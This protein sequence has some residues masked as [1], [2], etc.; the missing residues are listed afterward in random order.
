MEWA[1]AGP[2]TLQQRL[3]HLDAKKI[4]AMDVEDFVAVC[5]EKPAIHRFP[6]SMGRRIHDLCVLLAD[7]Y[8]GKGANVWKGVESGDEL[9]RRLREL[10]GY[11]EE[12]SKIFVAILGKRMSV[13]PTDWRV[14]AGVFG[15]DV[16][17]SVADI[18]GPESL[19][20]V[21]EW[22][23]A[24]KAAKK[25]KQDEPRPPERRHTVHPRHRRRPVADTIVL[26]PGPLRR[27]VRHLRLLRTQPG[28]HRTGAAQLAPADPQRPD[29]R[30]RAPSRQP[31]GDGAL[32]AP[33]PDL[34]VRDQ[35]C[36]GAPRRRSR[37]VA[38][39][40]HGAARSTA[41]DEPDRRDGRGAHRHRRRLDAHQVGPVRTDP[42]DRLD[43]DAA[44][45]APCSPELVASMAGGC[46]SL[47]DHRSDPAGRSPPARVPD[48][49][50][51][52]RGHRRVRLRRPAL[53]PA[54]SRRR[55]RC[56]RRLY[57]PAAARCGVVR[58]CGQR[59]QGRPGPRP[60]PAAGAVAHTRGLL[61]G[62]FSARCRIAI[63]RSSPAG[64]RASRS[65]ASSLRSWS[66][67]ASS[68]QS[69]SGDHARGPLHWPRPPCCRSPGRSVL[70]RS[71]YRLAYEIVPGFDLARGAA[72]WVVIVVLV[73]ALF[74]GVGVDVIRR[75]AQ[76]R[77]VAAAMIAIAGVVGLVALDVVD[78]FD[79]RSGSHLGR[80]PRPWRWR[81]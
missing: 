30:W 24:Q 72:R 35:P 79:R 13:E 7:R 29:L 52:D 56:A 45:G 28:G 38:R 57:R 75:R 48:G 31:V 53:A 43:S 33:A 51:G 73:A 2:A 16:P 59:D 41:R 62:H 54:R 50:V 65:S 3:G 81:C 46:C 23:K 27:R 17:R 37:R 80:S 1:F 36:D 47:G 49:R 44:R 21:R 19:G 60:A 40:R 6:A 58:H 10:P 11:G 77:H 69:S 67:S 9:Y 32:P 74:A 22:K 64:S 34:A 63:R 42:G 39:C 26:V 70:E 66:P 25:D 71:I 5:C 15:D 61:F 14:A 4:A 68:R 12:K 76:R 20:K 55:G 78:T 18:D 8:G